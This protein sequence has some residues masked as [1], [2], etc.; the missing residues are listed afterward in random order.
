VHPF[1]TS[2][3]QVK[4]IQV[5]QRRNI[6]HKGD[7]SLAYT[8]GV[9]DCLEIARMLIMYINTAKEFSCGYYQWNSSLGLGDIG[10]EASKVMEGKPYC[11]K[12][13]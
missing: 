1:N 12:F 9:A 4:K 5:V 10:P 6:Q 3:T 7:L 8:P 11:L 2:L 13:C